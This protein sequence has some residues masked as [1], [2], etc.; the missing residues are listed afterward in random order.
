[1]TKAFLGM[2]RWMFG[3]D[4]PEYSRLSSRD[5]EEMME[6][7]YKQGNRVML[8]F[9]LA[10]TV[11]AISF[12]FFYDTWVVTGIVCGVVWLMFGWSIRLFPRHF[13]TRCIAGLSLQFFVALHIYQLHGLEDAHSF[14]F[15]GIA[16]LLVYQDWPILW[17]S[18]LFLI[19]HH[20]IF[21]I[22][23][24]QGAPL[25]LF[26]DD[27][28]RASKLVFHLSLGVAQVFVCG[29]W[30]YMLRRTTIRNVLR[31][32]NLRAAN[33][34]L[35]LLI[36]QQKQS[37]QRLKES[38]SKAEE[39][40]ILLQCIMDVSPDWIFAKNR[41]FRLTLVNQELAKSMGMSVE[42]MQGKT[43]L[44]LVGELEYP[45]DYVY[46]NSEDGRRGFR[47]DDIDALSGIVVRS[48]GETVRVATGEEKVFDIIRMPIRNTSGEIVGVLGV[49]R[50]ITNIKRKEEELRHAKDEALAANRAKSAFLANMSHEIR[51]PMNAILGFAEILIGKLADSPLQHYAETIYTGGMG[52]LTIINDILDLSKIEAGRM[53]LEYRAVN[54]YRL[55]EELY[56]F[57]QIKLK[58]K[59]LEFRLE[60]D[61]VLPKSLLLDEVRLRQILINL[62]GNAVKFTQT[63][64]IRIAV[65]GQESEH[66]ESD[67]KL[68]FEVQDSGTGIRKDQL[69]RI[70]DAFHQQSG[71]S[72]R[73]H[74]GTGLG[75]NITRRFVE[76][77][78]GTITVESTEGE[79]STFTVIFP[80]VLI[81]SLEPD[82]TI[83]TE[84][85]NIEFDAA[86][87]LI[88]D[89]SDANRELVKEYLA[90]WNLSLLE[91]ENGVIAVE[92]A[93]LH[94]PDAIIMD[95]KMPEMDGYTATRLLVADETTS[96]IPIIALTA[97]VMIGDRERAIELGCRAFL[98]KPVSRTELLQAL[99]QFLPHIIIKR[100]NG[101]FIGEFSAVLEDELLWQSPSGAELLRILETTYLQQW[102][103]INVVI[104]PEEI[105][106]FAG[107]LKGL[108]ERYGSAQLK[109]Y[110]ETLE[111]QAIVMQF[112][113]LEKT[114]NAYPQLLQK[115]H[116]LIPLK[117]DGY[118]TSEG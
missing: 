89:D 108:A 70:F 8:V 46:G 63:G 83:S 96:A 100:N 49:G 13:I 94:K 64:Y 9:L 44:E 101:D 61:P 40:R 58:E 85:S 104:V 30:A 51:T 71:Q 62:V 27:Y 6:G 107:E 106:S 82:T 28:I 16:M 88:V 114:L 4:S 21:A 110:A 78:G 14:F 67:V 32:R 111:Q 48:A 29:Y 81:G 73:Q 80:N 109:E 97:S 33:E 65:Y 37:E 39:Y 75:L 36:E 20:I 34:D 113:L 41:D 90:P 87:V 54:L 60:V 18:I 5:Q 1:M 77:M 31:N 98:S 68:I 57:F 86:T 43:D 91:A 12:A 42:Y 66:E 38:Y 17:P 84:V 7:V 25:Y 22:Y 115:F 118:E 74:G 117:P 103:G 52:L 105:Q 23:Q 93:R 102:E 11:A 59:G 15:I 19:V 56:T 76:M 72:V 2:H 112:V 53:E 92:Q 10:H 45:E 24:N 69:Q 99:A 47:Q 50:D 116:S 55:L 26:E 95:M 35:S 79:G 3:Q